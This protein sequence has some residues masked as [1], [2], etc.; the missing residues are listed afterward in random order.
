MELPPVSSWIYSIPPAFVKYFNGR[1]PSEAIIRDQSGKS[2]HVTLEE[3]KNIVFF[4]DGWQEFVDSHHLKRGYFLVF[5]YDGSHV[6]DVKIFGKNGCKKELV[7][8]IGNPVPTV[9]VKDE[10][11]SEQDYS[12]SLTR[13]KRSDSEVRSTDSSATA[14]KSRRRSPSN[15]EEHSPS[16]TAEHISKKSPTFKHIVKHWSHKAIHIPQSVIVS[17][18]FLLKPNLIIIDDMGRSW[19]VK[20]T[21][22]SRGRFSLT[23]G[24]GAFFIANSLTIDDECTFE[25]V[26]DSNNLCGELK[27]KITRSL[28][29][30]QQEKQTTIVQEG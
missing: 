18:D 6:F 2:W 15:L 17:N 10:P 16:K 20:A 12:T 14:P 8:R 25:F 23:T 7:A 9:K 3:L 4:K 29:I 22:I 26:L 13:S 27:V 11:L 24:W 19:V 5:Q 1:I 28:E 21:P 30:T